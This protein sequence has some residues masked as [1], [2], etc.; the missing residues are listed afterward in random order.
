MTQLRCIQYAATPLKN[1]SVLVQ[2]RARPRCSVTKVLSGYCRNLLEK[3]G[4]SDEGLDCLA[5]ASAGKAKEADR[6]ITD[7]RLPRCSFTR[8]PD[9]LIY[10][11]EGRE[12]YLL[13]RYS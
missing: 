1:G 7:R 5:L 9:P 4:L 2:K 11:V 3:N 12:H 13:Q 6:E 8:E 10:G